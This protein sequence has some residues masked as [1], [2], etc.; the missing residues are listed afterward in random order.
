VNEVHYCINA[1][2][3][4]MG[5]PCEAW[6]LMELHKRGD[7]PGHFKKGQ[8]YSETGRRKIDYVNGFSLE[9]ASY[10]VNCYLKHPQLLKKDPNNPSLDDS[11]NVIRFECQY[12]Y[13]KVYNIRNAIEDAN[14][15]T[16]LILSDK[17]AEESVTKYFSKTIMLGDYY[18]LKK[19][20]KIIISKRFCP[21]K[22]KRLLDT[23]ELVSTHKGIH[24]AREHFGDIFTKVS[25]DRSLKEL[26]AMDINPVTI[27]CEW[28]F[29]YLPNLLK[30]YREM[31]SSM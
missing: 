4:E 26:V 23:L 1:D 31:K 29:D 25:F 5:Y 11:K 16:E 12:K 15:C 27:P 6:Q 28:G 24:M 21:S 9:C 30:V 7:V 19:A 10:N 18:S 8:E 22:E 13:L 20:R 3:K 14:K 2:V 17:M